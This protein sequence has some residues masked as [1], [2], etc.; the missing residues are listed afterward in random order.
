MGLHFPLSAISLGKA[1]KRGVE[2]VLE[3]GWLSTGPRV[4]QFEER[5]QSFLKT[6]RPCVAL[7]SGTSALHLSL[8]LAQIGPGDEVIVPSLTFVATVN[9]VL[10]AG[11]TP[12]FADI[13][14][15]EEPTIDPK[16]VAKK[17][18]ARTKAVI[19]MHYGGYPCRMKEL[20]QVVQKKKIFLI[21]DAAHAPGGE[22]EGESL[23]TLGDFGCFSFFPNK[24]MTTAEGGMLVVSNPS[25][26]KEAK[27]RRSHGMTVTSLDKKKGHA[28]SYDVP[29]LGYN[30]RMDELRAALGLAQL[31]RL[32]KYNARRRKIV[33]LYTKLLK[34]VEG[35][36]MPWEGEV[37]AS[38]CHLFV[39]LLHNA[40]LRDSL[41][42]Y[43]R[44]RG[45]QT[46]LHYPPVHLFS[47][48][49]KQVPTARVCLKKTEDFAE[50][51]VTLPLH[52]FL[53]AQDVMEIAGAVKS[54]MQRATS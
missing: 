6:D 18:T 49:Q 4:L 23:G 31:K 2:A 44:K 13:V 45:I 48:Y 41:M 26:A 53:K 1:E 19:C 34:K 9:A 12:V 37:A 40:A 20:R 22:Y 10:Y 3:E 35:L 33:S 51:A 11:A 14:S 39:I 30:Y 24:N 15:C 46:S 7:S 8:L 27:Q 52:P 38:A 28:F 50:R 21:E 47:Y 25:L 42:G 16:E 17:I 54:F 43:L 5:F 32:P 36:T 29:W